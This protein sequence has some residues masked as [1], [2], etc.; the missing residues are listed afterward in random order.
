MRRLVAALVVAIALGWAVYVGSLRL[1]SYPFFSDGLSCRHPAPEACGGMVPSSSLRGVPRNRAG[2][3]IPVS[4]LLGVLGVA[5]GL[6]VLLT[7]PKRPSGKSPQA[8]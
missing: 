1:G 7:D 5:G 3:Q 6:V 4:A 2:W 8:A